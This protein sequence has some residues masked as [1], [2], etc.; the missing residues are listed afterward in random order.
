MTDPEVAYG[1]DAS[2]RA[3]GDKPMVIARRVC[4]VTA[5]PFN[6]GHIWTSHDEE[7]IRPLR[8]GASEPLE[9]NMTGSHF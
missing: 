3:T 6:T 2:F 8:A 7:D 5:P 4:R 9:L 1:S